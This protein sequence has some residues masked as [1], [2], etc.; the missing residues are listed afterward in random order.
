MSD[1][2][3]HLARLIWSVSDLLRGDFKT[4]DYGKVILPFTVL[5][6]LDCV[7]APTRGKVQDAADNFEGG[8]HALE[9]LLR[10]ASGQAFFNTSRLTLE[11]VA[12]SPH[13]TAPL[14][15]DY[16]A[17]LSDNA[18]EVME[19]FELD[20]TIKRLYD[21]DLLY[22]VIS[23][24]VSLDLGPT[25]TSHQMGLVFEELV[26]HFAEHSSE[27]ASEHFTPREVVRLMVS[28]LTAPDTDILTL[29][30]TVRS[31]LDP[32]CGTGGL[33]SE[34]EDYITGLNPQAHVAL[35]GQEINAETWAICRSDMMMR[36]L[37]PDNIAY[38]NVLSRDGHQEGQFDYL[39]A[40]PPFGSKWKRVADAVREEHENLG[41]R[42][43]FGA[44]LPRINDGSLLF[45]QH[46]LSK[47]KTV[48]ASGIGGS[49]M[50]VIFNGSPMHVG[51]PGSGESDIRKWIIENDWLEAVVALPDQLFHN[52][53]IGTYL[54]V[55][56]NRKSANRRGSVVLVNA[57]DQWQKMRS[58]VGGKRKY[59][60]PDQIGE[61]TRLC[62]EALPPTS[63]RPQH[64]RVRVLRNDELGHRRI[65]IEQPLRLRYELSTESLTQLAASRLVQQTSTADALLASLRTLVG[66]TWSTSSAAFAA[67]RHAVAA[68]GESWPGGAAFNRAVRKAIGVRA[69]QGEVQRSRGV[70][71]PDLELRTFVDLA[72]HEDPEDYLR[73]E[74]HPHT[75][76]AWIDHS[77]TR[78]GY[79]IA[80][81]LF[82]VA[83]FVGPVEPLRHFAHLE[84]VR[85]GPH[86]DDA[87]EPSETDRPKHLRAQDLYQAESAVELPDAPKE[88]PA[89]TPCAGG[90]LVGRP[91]KWR[92]LPPG[93]GEAATS[94]FVLHPLRGSGRALC[95]WLNSLKENG[96]FPNPRD[97]LDLPVPVALV[98]DEEVDD[99]LT[100]VQEGR[101][102]LRSATSGILPNIFADSE[103]DIQRLREQVRSAAYEARLVG[104][105]VRPLGDPVWR[106]EWSYPYHV[107]ALAHRYRIS[108]HPAERKDGLLKLGEGIARTLGL[109]AL[110]EIVA[111]EGFTRNVRNKFRTGA[112]FGTWLTL[113]DRLPNAV[114]APR[115]RELSTLHGRDNAR[116]LLGEIKDFR[117]DSHH[118]HGVRA[119]HELDEDVDKLEPYVVSAIS[120]VSWLSG[121]HWDWVERCEYVDESS[122]KLVGLRLRGSHPSWE[123]FERSSTYPLRPDRIYVDS[124]PSGPP[125]DLWPLAAVSLCPECR[126][127]ELFLLNQVRD[128][129][130]TL[131]SLEEHTL[132]IPDSEPE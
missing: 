36:G 90:N 100:E 102:T 83:E 84:T 50:A 125:V 74:V 49:R 56:S 22:L 89:L 33:L 29:P 117:N 24:F 45:L 4:S 52:T 19:R 61:I 13:N 18:R 67:L 79:A 88:S 15:R 108:T 1:E 57:Q 115:L 103:T 86:R 14:L 81:A 98:A 5:R 121:T 96:Q 30:G 126:T 47:M 112:T 69:S 63:D 2:S 72:L 31:V 35:Y 64:A 76:N 113:I 51:A 20:Q 27:T 70:T 132:E 120:S 87:D 46:M 26:R 59:I 32:V 131:R 105:L 65:T 10:V 37:D 7:L 104:E 75:P 12:S 23:K 62:H 85:I 73:R 71:E 16:V 53:S 58:T 78:V 42:G 8:G 91:G 17:G 48:D 38:G 129:Q 93:F 109:L 82:L 123:P 80:P 54:W 44:G 116:P 122:Y 28:L 11:D 21:T 124:T 130:L 95:E 110:S 111:S 107:A 77:R 41:Y 99:L 114:D 101:R 40:N 43:R 3:R 34:A 118:A 25:V 68:G 106:A 66:S 39:L 128:G 127:R 55:L 94:L 9:A 119:T 92:L 97:L 60:G 6:R